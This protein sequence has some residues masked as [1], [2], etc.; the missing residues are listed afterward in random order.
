M[1]ATIGWLSVLTST[2]NSRPSNGERSLRTGSRKHWEQ[3]VL[4]AE[5]CSTGPIHVS[6]IVLEFID[7]TF[8]RSEL[9][10]LPG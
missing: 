8:S 3:R 5:K 4:G 9:R 10:G 6:P 1:R 7:G 2:S